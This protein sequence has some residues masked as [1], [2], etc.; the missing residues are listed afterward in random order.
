M[1]SQVYKKVNGRYHK[2]GYSDGFTGFPTE[3]I[4]LV[5]HGDGH[6]SSECILRI[7]DNTT[8]LPYASNVLKYKE[9]L[10]KFISNNPNVSIYNITINDFVN[11]L[12]KQLDDA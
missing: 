4:W 12:L 8:V 2:V 3:G 6:K 7:A 9:K 5:T 1:D 10:V 11:E